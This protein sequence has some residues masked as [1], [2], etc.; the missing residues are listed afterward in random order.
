MELPQRLD[1]TGIVK[2]Y[3]IGL[4]RIRVAKMILHSAHVHITVGFPLWP[5]AKINTIL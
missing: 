1:Q 3:D 5:N 4:W 2:E